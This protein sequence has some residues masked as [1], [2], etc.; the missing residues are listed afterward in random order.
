M[1]MPPIETKTPSNTVPRGNNVSH[2]RSTQLNPSVH[3]PTSQPA[4]VSFSHPSSVPPVTEVFIHHTL[5]PI[6]NLVFHC[7]L[8]QLSHL[9]A[10]PH[11]PST[12]PSASPAELS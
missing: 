5:L 1:Q 3:P 4:F 11:P 2:T 8:V 10:I 7:H 6:S 9:P 12:H